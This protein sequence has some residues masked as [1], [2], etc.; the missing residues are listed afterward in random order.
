MSK[1]HAYVRRE[2]GSVI[3]AL[4][5][6]LVVGGIVVTLMATTVMGQR[7]VRFD[8]N[9][10]NAIH[11]ADS[12]VHASLTRINHAEVDPDNPVAVGTKLEIAEEDAISGAGDDDTGFWYTATKES[13]TRWEIESWG[14]AQD[15]TLRHVESTIE[16]PPIFQYAAFAKVNVGTSGDNCADSYDSDK[17]PEQ[18]LNT[19]KGVIGTNGNINI[20]SST[21]SCTD[22][23]E[24]HDFY[25]DPDDPHDD[26]KDDIAKRVTICNSEECK[27]FHQLEEQG[28]KVFGLFPKPLVVDDWWIERSLSE[29]RD[30]RPDGQTNPTYHRACNDDGTVPGA[31]GTIPDSLTFTQDSPPVR[32]TVYCAGSGGVS[33]DRVKNTGEKISLKD[34]DPSSS[35]SANDPVVI[36]TSGPITVAGQ[37]WVNCDNCAAPTAG[38]LP[39]GPD[40]QIYSTGPRLTINQQTQI[41][42][43]L[44]A[45]RAICDGGADVHVWGAIVCQEMQNSGTWNFHFDQ[46]S[47]TP[48]EISYRITH[49]HEEEIGA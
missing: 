23:I 14:R 26:D 19:G 27:K 28:G 25:D 11:A 10:S 30:A 47:R 32:G 35:H 16:I 21:A 38:T 40:L 8:R 3:L 43:L 7:Q 2:D 48:S 34:P 5:A 6:A 49:W 42:A 31:P 22:G 24:L 12:G 41:G 39:V 15:G 17:D 13:K 44:Y 1:I 9:F 36:Y 37:I 18:A 4:L 33:F 20:A 29:K 46:S 45:P